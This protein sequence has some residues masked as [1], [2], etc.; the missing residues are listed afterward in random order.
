MGDDYVFYEINPQVT[1]L[2][3]NLFDFLHRS[4]AQVEIIPG[5]GRLSLQR[6]SPQNFD[7][8]VVDAFSGD[9]IP[10]HLLTREA[11][12]LYF[13]HLKPHGLLAMH[14]TNRLLNLPPVIEATA[15]ALGARAIQ[16]TNSEDEQNAVYE[17]TWMLLDRVSAPN[18]TVSNLAEGRISLR[19]GRRRKSSMKLACALGQTI[20][21]A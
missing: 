21:A 6:E 1:D 9:A 5:D 8:L 14:V 13:R 11:F 10:V 4:D 18:A 2:A 17:S 16:V 12:E 3:T 20:T 7:V 15:C 19:P